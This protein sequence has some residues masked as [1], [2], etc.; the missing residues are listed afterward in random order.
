[1]TAASESSTRNKTPTS[2]PQAKTAAAVDRKNLRNTTQQTLEILLII[3]TESP[4]GFEEKK[5]TP[6]TPVKSP[7]GAG[8]TT[9]TGKGGAPNIH[10]LELSAI[11]G[12]GEREFTM[13]SGTKS[14]FNTFILDNVDFSVLANQIFANIYVLGGILENNSF[15]MERYDIFK[16]KWEDVAS[17]KNNRV[18][19][20]ALVLPGGNLLIMGGK[21]VT[22]GFLYSGLNSLIGWSSNRRL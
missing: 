16:G 22:L 5:N 3:T 14:D 20:S 11:Q 13:E 21:Q 1:M 8:M 19:F 15:T 7:V 18:K 2:G 12:G 10:N 6:S 4:G 9:S 17:L